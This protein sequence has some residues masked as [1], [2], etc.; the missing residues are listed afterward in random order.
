MYL[1]EMWLASLWEGQTWLFCVLPLNKSSM[2][3]FFSL[4]H[5]FWNWI[6]RVQ[7]DIHQFHFRWNG[8]EYKWW[9]TINAQGFCI[10]IQPPTSSSQKWQWPHWRS[11]NLYIMINFY[12]FN[13]KYSTTTGF[14][15]D[16][17][18][19]VKAKGKLFRKFKKRTIAARSRHQ[20]LEAQ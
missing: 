6:P 5:P 20:Y 2:C 3:V 16:Q 14:P 17:Y 19:K 18:Y 9:Y 12:M 7:E 4:I 11:I 8:I 15:W 10:L 1:F 13:I